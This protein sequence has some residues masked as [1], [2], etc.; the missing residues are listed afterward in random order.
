[1]YRK[2]TSKQIFNGYEILPSDSVLI[3]DQKGAI[4]DILPISEAGDGIIF[5]EG[6]ISP[7]FINCHCHLELSH[8]KGVI[9]KKTGLIDFVLK[10]VQGRKADNTIIQEAM[11]KAEKEMLQNGIVAVG[12]ICNT[13]Y[14][15]AQKSKGNLYYH[16]FIE[17]IG[18]PKEI[19]IS[20]FQ[21]MKELYKEF[22]ISLKNNSLV[23][24]AP[25]S[26]STDLLTSIVQFPGN[27]IITMHNQETLE[28]NEL[29]ENKQGAFLN[30]FKQ[31]NINANSFDALGK[32]SLQHFLPFF[33]KDQSL[34]LV[35]N[36]F[37]NQQDIEFANDFFANT[38]SLLNFCLCP[39]ANLYIN[40]QL[41]DVQLFIKNQC[42]IV[43]GTDSL[44]SNN[45]LS[46]LEEIITLQKKYPTI[47]LT[48]MLQWATI[49]GAKA[50]KISDRFG[51]FEIGKTPGVLL[52]N[53]EIVKRLV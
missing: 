23:P 22:T 6:L 35:H 28:E 27:E 12:D 11:E 2:I 19:A 9:P 13:N 46:I 7:G 17:G 52:I 8:L 47:P 39:N 48:T 26:V 18:F 36:I 50:L 34:I 15:I 41:P 38:S 14:S 24:H 32:T 49:N 45:Q 29:Y 20:R 10:I 51:S 21:Q 3:I 37:T 5:H 25:Y 4:A 1:M 31:L 16:N 40:H 42:S 33:K 44:A 43:L 30:F 53:D